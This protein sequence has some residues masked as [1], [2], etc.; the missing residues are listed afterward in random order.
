MTPVQKTQGFLSKLGL[1]RSYV[2]V[3]A[4]AVAMRPGKKTVGLRVLKTN[5][6]VM[7]ARHGLYDRLLAGGKL[8][9]IVAFGDVAHEAYDLWSASNSAVKAVR[10]IQTRTPCSRGSGCKWR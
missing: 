10:A 8:Q 6:A 3:N 5:A 7:A 1:T 2:L 4:F 9:A